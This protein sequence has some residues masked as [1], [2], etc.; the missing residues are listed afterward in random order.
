LQQ[1]T[2]LRFQELADDGGIERVQLGAE[3]PT[4]KRSLHVVVKY[5]DIWSVSFNET[6]TVP[7]LKSVARKRS[8][9][10]VTD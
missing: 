9:E 10:S 6:V 1:R 3:S 7:V 5:S 8:V 4:A 2:G